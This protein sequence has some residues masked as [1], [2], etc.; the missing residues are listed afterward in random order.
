MFVYALFAWVLV[1][2]VQVFLFRPASSTRVETYD[3]DDLP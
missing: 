1:K 3:R 2:V